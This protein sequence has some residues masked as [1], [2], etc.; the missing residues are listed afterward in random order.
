MPRI[1][2]FRVLSVCVTS[3]ATEPINRNSC[4]VYLSCGSSFHFLLRACSQMIVSALWLPDWLWRNPTTINRT[5]AQNPPQI[6][7]GPGGAVPLGAVSMLHVWVRSISLHC[8]GTVLYPKPANIWGCSV[9]KQRRNL[10]IL[11]FVSFIDEIIYF[12]GLR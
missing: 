4:L 5:G 9:W 1:W 3:W 7:G 12:K 10:N 2:N 11:P 8:C 6:P